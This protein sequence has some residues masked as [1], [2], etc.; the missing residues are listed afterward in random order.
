MPV[1][2]ELEGKDLIGS[3]W[4]R[5]MGKHRGYKWTLVGFT[6]AG[7]KIK[8]YDGQK[9]KPH[10]DNSQRSNLPWPMFMNLYQPEGNLHLLVTVD[11]EGF[12]QSVAKEGTNGMIEREAV[13]DTVKMR[14]CLGPWHRKDGTG[15][16]LP[17][18]MFDIVKMGRYHGQL[19]KTCIEC[20]A[21]KNAN[22]RERLRKVKLIE[23]VVHAPVDPPVPP[24]KKITMDRAIEVAQET[25]PAPRVVIVNKKDH[26]VVMH[27]SAKAHWKVTII[28]A[29]KETVVE[30]EADDFL[31]A[32]IA[33]GEGE[34]LK[35]ERV[36]E[37]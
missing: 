19:A 31:E 15:T 12:V 13:R 5:R 34:V 2:A 37:D 24:I 27:G 4:I 26:P 16:M 35:V 8:V 1:P 7:V 3:T 30:V 14:S 28:P 17:E 20:R 9:L 22:E 11:K 18:T 25:R 21:K 6:E 33:A 29:P 32:A 36:K 23:P 10:M